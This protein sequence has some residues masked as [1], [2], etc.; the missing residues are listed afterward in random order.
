MQARAK[1]FGHPIH[2]MLI[3]F[4]LGLLATSLI[5]DVMRLAANNLRWS[6]VAF[7]VMVAGVIGGV[8]AAPF[9]LVDWLAI[10]KGTRARKVGATHGLGNVLV[11]AAF[12]VSLLLR[13]DPTLEPETL[14]YVLSFAGGG[15]SVVTG[16]LGGE[17]VDRMGVGVHEGAN[18]NAPSSLSDAMPNS[19]RGEVIS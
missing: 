17:L 9:G 12:T 15:L 3:V 7:Y 14:A 4:P 1:L 18:V 8:L 19:A 2:Q 5:F 10:P 6:E 11:L 16:W 13:K